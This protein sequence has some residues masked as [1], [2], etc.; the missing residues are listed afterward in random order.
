MAGP[1]SPTGTSRVSLRRVFVSLLPLE[2]RLAL[3]TIQCQNLQ[4]L[5][6]QQCSSNE[7][8][9]SDRVDTLICESLATF[10]AT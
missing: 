4:R 2:D 1:L 7:V 5:A 10:A 8:A 6:I 3:R 9:E